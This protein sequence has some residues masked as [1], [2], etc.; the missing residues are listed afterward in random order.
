VVVGDDMRG[1]VPTL[2]SAHPSYLDAHLKEARGDLYAERLPENVDRSVPLWQRF[3]VQAVLRAAC[4]RHRIPPPSKLMQAK[5]TIK[6]VKTSIERS[7]F[8]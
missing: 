1:C 3:E 4:G 5:G 2:T 7:A 6:A 8:S